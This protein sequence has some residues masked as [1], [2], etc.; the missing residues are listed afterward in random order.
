MPAFS[1]AC[2]P[3]TSKKPP[4]LLCIT[5][6]KNDNNVLSLDL[7]SS[8]FFHLYDSIDE[9]DLI[10]FLKLILKTILHRVFYVVLQLIYMI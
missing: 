8:D 10:D 6:R 1:A 9:D 4:T 7:I 2:F 3:N 5:Q